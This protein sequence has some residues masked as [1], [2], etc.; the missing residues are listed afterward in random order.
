M[1]LGFLCQYANMVK[2]EI[3]DPLKVTRTVLVVVGSVSSLLT[4]TE[5]VIVESP[6]D[7]KDSPASGLDVAQTNSLLDKLVV[8]KLNGG[9]GT[10]MGYTKYT[11]SKLFTLHLCLEKPRN[12]KPKNKRGR[13]FDPHKKLTELHVPR[14]VKSRKFKFE[15]PTVSSLNGQ[16]ESASI[17]TAKEANL[18]AKLSIL[19]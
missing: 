6:K 9:L 18:K 19:Q 8:L 17:S 5:A 12:K 16:L 7:E 2:E 11:E 1:C 4:T 14:T 15:E 10:T 3:I 13:H